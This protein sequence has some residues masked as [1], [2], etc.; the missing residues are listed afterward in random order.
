MILDSEEQRE[1]LMRLLSQ[2]PIETN[3]AE[4]LKG[5]DPKIIALLKAIQEAEVGER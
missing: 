4:I 1:L 5:L 3:I 2:V